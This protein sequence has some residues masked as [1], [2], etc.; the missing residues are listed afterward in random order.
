MTGINFIQIIGYTASIII[1]ISMTQN[2]I[3]KFRWINLMGATM[4]STYGIVFGAYPVGIL[5]GFIVMVDLYYLKKIY[6]KKDIFD[7]LEIR[8]DNKYLL[9]FLDFHKPEIEK[10]FPN[11]EYKPDINTISF[12]VLRN[13]AVAGIFLA[14]EEGG[15]V[16]KVGL[17]YAVPEYRDFKSGKFV[18]LSMR[19]SLI[20]KGITKI[21]A[22]G[23]TK[24]H[25]N[26]LKKCGFVK[27]TENAYAKFL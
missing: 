5:N 10:S 20:E 26:Y 17:D 25:I 19:K 4:F 8:K 18:Y 11:F 23:N 2:S 6:F 12:F 22:F 1:A 3:V 7:T 9:K 21:I 16:L 27:A 13:T 15:N 14:H 24:K